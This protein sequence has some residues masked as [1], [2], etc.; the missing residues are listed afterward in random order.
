MSTDGETT[1]EQ[2]L[3]AAY[4]GSKPMRFTMPDA[5]KHELAGCIAIRLEAPVP[6][7]LVVSRGFTELGP[8]VEDDPE[9]SGWGFELTC[10]L[11]ARS[12]EPDFGWIVNWMENVSAYLTSQ[13]T[14][15]EPYHHIPMWEASSD[16]ELAALVFI[17]ESAL[18]PTRSENGSVAFL[19][20]VGLT[21]GEYDALQAWDPRSLVALI[22]QRDPLLLMDAARTTYLR[23]PEFAQ[24]VEQG[25]ARDGSSTD[26]LHGVSILWFTGPAG[27]EV[28]M[29]LEALALVKWALG[30]RLAHGKSM[31]L[32]GERR[33]A[34]RPDGSLAVRS[35]VNVV[36]QPEKG[37]SEIAESTDG[38]KMCLLR[39]SAD[40]RAEL[41]GI[42]EEAGK[43]TLPNLKGVTIFV[44]TV[45]RLR[46]PH[47]P[48]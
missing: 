8:K 36:L 45:D 3:L 4:P 16:D 13:V 19:Q 42:P 11:P 14:V 27:I 5:E 1:I 35:Q 22:Q 31:L 28:H 40:A 12:E 9:V 44:A 43:H 25:H 20:M 6:H 29:S 18:E 24:A 41:G 26:V 33:K 10:R 39:L 34:V 23:D 21:N 30:A 48:G 47:Y 32:F 37:R 46:E 2:A 7:W 17:E 38:G 15:L